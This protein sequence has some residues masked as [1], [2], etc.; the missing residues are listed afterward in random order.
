MQQTG[1]FSNKILKLSCIFPLLIVQDVRAK[2]VTWSIPEDLTPGDYIVRA[3]GDA[4]YTCTDK[5]KR[6]FCPLQLEDRV[7]I[8]IEGPLK[9]ENGPQ[10]SPECP[11]NLTPFSKSRT[12]SP[13]SAAPYASASSTLHFSIDPEVLNLLESNNHLGKQQRAS[14]SVVADNDLGE[15]SLQTKTGMEL[16][17]DQNS[18]SANGKTGTGIGKNKDGAT[19]INGAGASR[20]ATV[21]H[22]G[23]GS[24]LAMVMA[25]ALVIL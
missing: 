21:G 22:L 4:Y 7:T 17:Q 15:D 10:S 24:S 9:D 19:A 14:E 13:S 2:N 5:G 3:F 23:P 6:T 25:V 8:H 18:T 20:W 16:S 11:A 12:S 1:F